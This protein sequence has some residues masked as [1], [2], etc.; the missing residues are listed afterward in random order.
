MIGQILVYSQEKKAGAIATADGQRLIFP[1]QDWQDVLPPERGMMVEFELDED[2]RPRKVQ[3]A[4]VPAP[5][6]APAPAAAPPYPPQQPPQ[7]PQQQPPYQGQ[8]PPPYPPQQQ[9]PYQGQQPPQYPPHQY[10][11]H[12]YP[13]Q[14]YQ[15]QQYPGQQPP[16]YPMQQPMG[17]P[18]Q[19]VPFALRPKS[20]VALVLWTF[21]LGNLGAHRFYMGAWGLGLVQALGFLILGTLL[22]F[23]S[24]LA[25]S[26]FFLVVGIFTLV[27]F[28]RYIFTN[29]AKFNAKV[30]AWQA[31]RPGP[32][33]FFW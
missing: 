20:K 10:P 6:V 26:V 14:Q 2:K 5:A 1:I 29:E 31:Q 8:Q 21:F 32:F 3:L 4:P 13:P 9:P 25:S 15:G 22:D 12:Q 18:Y 27:E 17:Q 7:Y 24:P 16:P 33:S 19:A 30:Q 23:V 11:P 28:F